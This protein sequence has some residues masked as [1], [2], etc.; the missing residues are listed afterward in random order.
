[1]KAELNV[2]KTPLSDEQTLS[3]INDLFLFKKKKKESNL[4][5]VRSISQGI[6]SGM[7]SKEQVD[8]CLE[9]YF[10]D[11]KLKAVK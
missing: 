7:F 11:K 1:M 10:Q 5:V 9:Q 6:N 2:S 4:F 8:K 3:M